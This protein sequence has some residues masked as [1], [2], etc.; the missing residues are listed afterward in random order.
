MKQDNA[1]FLSEAQKI[2]NDLIAAGEKRG[3]PRKM[4]TAYLRICAK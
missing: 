4:L 2:V 1:A 3:M